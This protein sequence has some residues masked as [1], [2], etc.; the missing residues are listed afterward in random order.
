MIA[1]EIRA[2]PPEPLRRALCDELGGREERGDSVAGD[3]WTARFVSLPPAQ[4]GALRIATFR[5]EI[6]GPNAGMAAQLL[7]RL[8]TRGGG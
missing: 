5:V 6:S 4:V 2:L 3:G 7:R 1:L 8:T